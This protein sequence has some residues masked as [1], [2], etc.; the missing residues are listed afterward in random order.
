MQRVPPEDRVMI[1]A[2]FQRAVRE[3][4]PFAFLHRVLD[5]DGWIRTVQVYGEVVPGHGG[6]A[7]L[8]GVA[9][10]VTD[11]IPSDAAADARVTAL[12]ERLA[13]QAADMAALRK[14]IESLR[15]ELSA[16]YRM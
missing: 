12:E 5:R 11:Q 9:H 3:H 2:M 10:D 8:F 4:A 1:E 16:P 15:K 7:M 13:G 14:E 6:L